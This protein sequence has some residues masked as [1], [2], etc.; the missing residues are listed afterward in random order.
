MAFKHESAKAAAAYAIDSVA[1]PLPACNPSDNM[2][3]DHECCTEL[4]TDMQ[5]MPH[6]ALLTSASAAYAQQYCRPL[7]DSLP[8]CMNLATAVWQPKAVLHPACWQ[9][10]RW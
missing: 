9:V 8:I 2:S 3:A 6:V 10:H 1:D 5:V 4:A 7:L